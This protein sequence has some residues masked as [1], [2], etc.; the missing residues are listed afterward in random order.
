MKTVNQLM[1][2]IVRYSALVFFLLLVA[3]CSSRGKVQPAP[4]QATQQL[5]Q[6]INSSKAD[7]PNMDLLYESR[8]W[9]SP[10]ELTLD[11]VGAA[12]N[13]FIPTTRDDVK[14]LGPYGDDPLRS[15]ALKIWMIENA[16]HTI[17]VVYYIFTPDLVGQAILGALCNAVQRGV[18]VRIMVDA[19][20]SFNSSK[21]HFRA[22]DTCAENATNIRD[23]E[24]HLTQHRAR[25][26]MVIIN[27]L[28]NKDSKANRR[29]HDKLLLMDAEIPGKAA[30]I[31]GGRNISLDY[32]GINEDGSKDPDAF[33]DMEILVRPGND[34]GA[35]K[36]TMGHIAEIYFSLLFLHEGNRRLEAIEHSSNDENDY[37]DRQYRK[38]RN[39]A[40][41][42]LGRLKAFPEI[43]AILASMP[44]YMK[45]GFHASNVR[46]VHEMAH[47]T[48]ESVV[49]NT[50]HN[51]KENPNSIMH[52]LHELTKN[53]PSDRTI[54]TVSPYLFIARYYDKDGNLVMDR[55][56]DI[57]NWLNAHPN[58]RIEIITNSVLTSDNFMAQSVI[59]M[60]MGP[61][62]LLT[63]ELE[64]RWLSGLETG[65]LNSDVVESEEWKRLVEHPQLYLYQTGKLDSALLGNGSAHYGK[66][67]AKFIFGPE[68]A[69]VGT[70]N[71]DYRSQL[72]NNEMGLVLQS[73]EVIQDLENNFDR[74]KSDS[75]RWGSP[76]WLQMREELMKAGG[77]KGR[78]TRQQ[79]SI[80]K[81]M[82]ATGLEWL[83]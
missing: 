44:D 75:Y 20:G 17:D 19:V 3:A 53:L 40:Q 46:L 61:R 47:L 52:Q 43:Q 14:I 15:L 21:V 33:R 50:Q 34:R 9:V 58:N 51:L 4:L 18:D 54:R 32:Y 29:S 68:N 26:Q 11:P 7:V 6:E 5:I 79:R 81:S 74:L 66:L 42:A 76:E 55:V 8:S 60:E 38:Q 69:F 70:A 77:I 39:N 59:D 45:S 64:E 25:V 36:L 62:L 80:Y 41:Q 31:T 22:L 83:I 82:R 67:H 49:T 16:Q 63:P 13:T 48:D 23:A 35:D 57:H 2:S 71:F 12:K 27:A 72:F 78:T 37:F 56:A 73:G 30:F 24:G 65:E 10:Q 28:I 1:Y